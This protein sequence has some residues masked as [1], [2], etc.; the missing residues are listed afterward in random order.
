M[1]SNS[2]VVHFDGVSKSFG[3]TKALI[4]VNLEVP[5]GSII[6]LLGA[7]G[8][9]KSTLLRHMIGLYLPSAG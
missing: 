2:Q 9:G 1:N 5:C 6:G 8:A 3:A 7:N 4:D